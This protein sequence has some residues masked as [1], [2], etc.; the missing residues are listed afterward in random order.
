MRN[1]KE[2]YVLFN[3]TLKT[4]F[5]CGY[6]ASDMWERTTHIERKPA[7]IDYSFQL[8]V[9]S[10]LYAPSHRQDSTYHIAFATPVVEY[11]LEQ[12]IAH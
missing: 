7:D 4:H 8:V 9:W 1:K 5:I 10:F 11:W 6:M 12:Q 3:D 2:R